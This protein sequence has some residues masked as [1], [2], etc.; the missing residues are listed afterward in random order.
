[1]VVYIIVS[2]DHLRSES[3]L[4]VTLQSG[5]ANWSTFDTHLPFC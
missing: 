3:R 5:Q 2:V 4:A 1:L